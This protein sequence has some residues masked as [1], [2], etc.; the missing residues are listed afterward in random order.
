[1]ARR[2]QVRRLGIGWILA[3]EGRDLAQ[4]LAVGVGCITP[5]TPRIGS[6]IRIPSTITCISGMHRG[7]RGRS[8][9]AQISIG[10]L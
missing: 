9:G 5:L 8:R 6:S 10:G 7:K 4:A 1:M 3:K 2:A